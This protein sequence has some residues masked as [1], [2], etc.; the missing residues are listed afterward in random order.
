MKYIKQFEKF[1][2]PSISISKKVSDIV[3]S[4]IKKYSGGKEFFKYLDQE[5]KNNEDIILSLVS[6]NENEYIVSTGGFGNLLDRLYDDGKFK[7]KGLL[8]FNGKMLTK[9][10]GVTTWSPAEFDLENKEFLFVDDSLFSGSTWKKIDEF[11]KENGSKIKEISV[12]YDG[13]VDKNPMVRSF[14]RYYK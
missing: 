8:V 10:K 3:S 11:L 6:G 5:I 13:S 12:V 2:S 14:Y 9:D 4:L 7:C 1:R